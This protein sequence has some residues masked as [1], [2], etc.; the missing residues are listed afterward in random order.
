MSS[1]QLAAPWTRPTPKSQ[2]S[3]TPVEELVETIGRAIEKSK[4][5]FIFTQ[6]ITEADLLLESLPLTTE[7]FGLARNRLQ[8]ATRYV[9]SGEFGAASWEL[10]SLRKFFS[11]QG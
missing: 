9:M 5:G 8:N 6:E 7:E 4:R 2:P 10:G 3:L 11:R 1:T